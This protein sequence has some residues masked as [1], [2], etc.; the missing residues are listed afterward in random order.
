MSYIK[1]NVR[2]STE[3]LEMNDSN[4]N[5]EHTTDHLITNDYENIDKHIFNLNKKI[6]LYISGI[7]FAYLLMIG[8]F[9]WAIIKR[10][11]NTNIIPINTN[12][13]SSSIASIIA[14][15]FTIYGIGTRYLAGELSKLLLFSITSKNSVNIVD[16]NDIVDGGLLGILR[17]MKY[18]YSQSASILIIM[19]A[20]ASIVPI[21]TLSIRKTI[22]ENMYQTIASTAIPGFFT[23]TSL[24]ILYQQMKPEI[25]FTNAIDITSA[26]ILLGNAQEAVMGNFL[27]QGVV[28]SLS[29]TVSV[30]ET[31]YIS[32]IINATYPEVL[33]F[34]IN[35][36][37]MP[38]NNTTYNFNTKVINFPSY[39]STLEVG[40]GFNSTAHMNSIISTSGIVSV[41]V[42]SPIHMAWIG[43][44]Y[45]SSIQ[46]VTNN[47]EILYS[48]TVA[49]TGYTSWLTKVVCNTTIDWAIQSCTWNGTAMV[50]CTKN[51]YANISKIDTV[52]L[53]LLSSYIRTVP[54]YLYF[55]D[56]V[57]SDEAVINRFS[58]LSAVYN[59]ILSLWA[60]EF[61][62]GNN[63]FSPMTLD[64]ANR[65]M[66]GT[67]TAVLDLVLSG[68]YGTEDY[69]VNVTFSSNSIIIRPWAAIYIIIILILVLIIIIINL[70]KYQFL[71]NVARKSSMLEIAAA[72]RGQWW[73]EYLYE[74]SKSSDPSKLAKSKGAIKV[75]YGIVPDSN[76][77]IGFSESAIPLRKTKDH[78]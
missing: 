69:I 31:G 18:T 28:Q 42:S 25:P 46:N 60:S 71:Y 47:G 40:S 70:I 11:S 16:F 20:G 21:G 59:G 38:D 44:A 77:Y 68:V 12:L 53:S 9:I 45:N 49:S 35:P 51:P 34:Q 37:C 10:S 73:D 5:N 63:G 66:L 3:Q 74:M 29:T 13:S 24:P 2:T 41:P 6:L 32:Y 26:G 27:T 52:S 19:L 39:S 64:K 75:K 61:I 58:S 23:G 15:I 55:S 62:I 14:V 33:V 72:T 43:R 67:A 1:Q 8:F 7:I 57:P 22:V 50:S 54:Y 48:N 76:G 56:G 36:N 65:L 78:K 30:H 4:K 17:L